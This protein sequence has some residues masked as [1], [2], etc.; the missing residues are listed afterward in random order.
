MRWRLGRFGVGPW[1]QLYLHLVWATWDR[2][3]LI[4]P[5][6]E[7]RL[8]AALAAKA[9]QLRCDP[10]AIG[11]VADHVHVL[12]SLPATVTVASLVKELKGAS[13]H[14]VTHE[15]TPGAEFRWQGGYGAFTLAR[16]DVPLLRRYVTE[17][18]RHHATGSTKEVWEQ[19]TSP[20]EWRSGIAP[21]PDGH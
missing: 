5:D 11:G 15:V 21:N 16:R 3:P 2:L 8:F 6:V 1:L 19:T 18:K 12:A 7:S 9:R 10:L 20:E 14:L 13:S 4:T 17:Q